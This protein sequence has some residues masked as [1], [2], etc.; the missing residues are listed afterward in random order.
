MR[1]ARFLHMQSRLEHHLGFVNVVLSMVYEHKNFGMSPR[2]PASQ[3]LE[4]QGI[5]CRF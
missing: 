1:F 3:S 4:L 5:T 2:D